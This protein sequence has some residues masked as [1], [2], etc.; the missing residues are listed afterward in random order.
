MITSTGICQFGTVC[1]GSLTGIRAAIFDFNGTIT[2]DEDLQYQVYAETFAEELGVEFSR[3]EYF[4]EFAG[5]PDSYILSAAFSRSSATRSGELEAHVCQPGARGEPGQP[6]AHRRRRAPQRRRD[7][8][9]PRTRCAGRQRS[10]D[11]RH[12]IRPPQQAAHRQQHMRD[13][14]APRTATAAAATASRSRPHPGP[15]AP[16]HAPTPPAGPHTQDSATRLPPAAARPRP[17]QRLP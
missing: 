15:H 10:P 4:S 16:G 9:V 13:P 6:A 3:E 14:A 8:P 11:H 17:Q 7:L 1:V 2:D 12:P 5:R